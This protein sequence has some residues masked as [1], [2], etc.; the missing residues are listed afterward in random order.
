MPKQ[1]L[2]PHAGQPLAG[3]LYQPPAAP[4]ASAVIA[5]GL[6][7]SMQS[8]KLS[9]LAHALADAGYLAL[10]FD[11]LG[12]GDSPGDVRQTTLTSRR[13]QFLAA[14]RFLELEAP[15]LPLAFMGS[16]LGGTAALLAGQVRPPIC[17]VCWSTPVDLTALMRRLH[18]QPSPPD[19]P[20]MVEDIPRHD[21]GAALAHTRGLLVV[22]G[23]ED[24]VVPVEQARLAFDLAAPPKDLLLLPGA[25]HRLSRLADQDQATART[26]AWL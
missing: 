26:L 6:Y 16:S 5:H 25:D 11:A 18:R 4:K 22:H 9:R 24:E 12:C 13:D 1:A 21:L 2:I 3:R 20:L 17:T 14:A 15:G 23:Q 10:M 7:S 19:L 8:Q